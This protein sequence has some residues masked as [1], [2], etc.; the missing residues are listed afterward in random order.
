MVYGSLRKIV[1]N[2]AKPNFPVHPQH[3]QVVNRTAKVTYQIN[4]NN[5]LTGFVNHNSKSQPDCLTATNIYLDVSVTEPDRVPGRRL[6]GRAAF[7]LSARRRSSRCGPA[8]ISTTGRTAASRRTRASRIN[9]AIVRGSDRFFDNIRSRPQVWSAL[10]YF[11]SGWGGTHN[12][13]FGGEMMDETFED[14]QDGHPGN[15]PSTP[16]TTRPTTSASTRSRTPR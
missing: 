8:K 4:T 12:F 6:E 13:K 5:K 1:N 16:A 10:S 2:V 9:S 3:T 7:D 11:K 15:G 14:V